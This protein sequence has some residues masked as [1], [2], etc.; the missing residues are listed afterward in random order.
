MPDG[1]VHKLHFRQLPAVEF[2]KFLFAENSRD[3]DTQASSA[4]RLVAASLCDADGKLALTRAQAMKLN[5]PA[6]KALLS[7]VL[8]V[9]GMG[10]KA[11]KND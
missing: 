11:A 7:A 2:R 4:P 6:L 8:D 9:N 5:P 3:E 10:D 1:T